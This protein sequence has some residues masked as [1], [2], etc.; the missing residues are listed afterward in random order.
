MFLFSSPVMLAV[1]GL[2]LAILAIDLLVVLRYTVWAKRAMPRLVALLPAGDG[3]RS[4]ALDAGHVGHL[5]D[6]P[7][8]AAAVR[9]DARPVSPRSASFQENP[10]V[11]RRD[12]AS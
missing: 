8:V 10:P 5:G 2:A 11:L 1:N 12:S 4:G 9:G 6:H 3:L 7:D